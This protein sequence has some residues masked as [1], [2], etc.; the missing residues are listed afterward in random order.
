M[1]PLA[2]QLHRDSSATGLGLCRHC[3]QDT[4]RGPG[5]AGPAPP[6]PPPCASSRPSWPHATGRIGLDV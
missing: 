4:G 3:R 6:T 1:R 5:R 2:P